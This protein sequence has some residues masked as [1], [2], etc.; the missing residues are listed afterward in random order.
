MNYP[1]FDIKA[2][3]LAIG[4]GVPLSVA[5]DAL[6]RMNGD[7][8]RWK[9]PVT[10]YLGVGSG[11]ECALS[12]SDALALASV[13]RSMRSPVHPIGLGVLRGFEAVVLV[14]GLPGKRYLTQDAM[15]C[16]DG[17]ASVEISLPNGSMGIQPH[18][19]S[20]REQAKTLIVN[21][22]VQFATHNG[23][24]PRFWDEARVISAQ[25]AIQARLADHLVPQLSPYL[26]HSS[27][28]QKDHV[29]SRSEF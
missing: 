8:R 29:S 10:L 21:H 18:N 17:L 5:M 11:T 26:F 13:I 12:G 7:S 4:H 6:L 19:M 1:L 16:I 20:L 22:L 23:L 2:R 9:T 3:T 14:S 24:P 28:Q 25:D 27:N 15:V